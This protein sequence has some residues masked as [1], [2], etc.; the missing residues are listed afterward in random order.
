M[1]IGFEGREGSNSYFEKS[2]NCGIVESK[3]GNG[4][5]AL[6]MPID[7]KES[8]SVF[9]CV[10]GKGG[11]ISF[12]YKQ[13]STI[14]DLLFYEEG[15]PKP[16][17]CPRSVDLVS[18]QLFSIDPGRQKLIWE[19][20]FRKNTGLACDSNAIMSTAFID[21]IRFTG[22]IKFCDCNMKEPEHPP[23]K[24]N[25]EGPS[26]VTVGSVYMYSAL[27]N[28][29]NNTEVK[30]IFKWGD[31]SQ[32]E[33]NYCLP[34]SEIKE[35]HVW[36][37]PGVYQMSVSA[38]SSINNMTSFPYNITIKVNPKEESINYPGDDINNKINNTNYTIFYLEEGHYK[39]TLY[40]GP[41]TNNITIKS[42]PNYRAHSSVI[43]GLNKSYCIYIFN[44]S[45]ITLEN[46]LFTNANILIKIYNSSN[47]K[48]IGNKF[49]NFKKYGVMILNSAIFTIED[50][51]LSSMGT[52][53]GGILIADSN[54]TTSHASIVRNNSIELPEKSFSIFLKRSCGINLYLNKNIKSFKEDDI[55][56]GIIDENRARTYRCN[57]SR[58]FELNLSDRNG[59]ENFCSNI[60]Q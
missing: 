19:Y 11:E 3:E 18:S 55:E 42:F 21:D 57:N 40:I 16:T 6:K 35:P 9:V 41:S 25:V 32:N 46:I 26:D 53:C 38:I 50:N 4:S 45:N 49:T 17:E 33:T 56:C 23:S 14:A 43:D 58:T 30:Y 20:K 52:N 24:P 1:F 15:D 7:S 31:N 29:I 10:C 12:K 51:K 13:P 28:V 27:S 48:I 8:G 60:I 39:N 5:W 44:T 34:S 37:K 36:R 59:L 47:I 22:D 54:S 2:S